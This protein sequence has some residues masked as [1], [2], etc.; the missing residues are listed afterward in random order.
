MPKLK[1]PAPSL[2]IYL[3]GGVGVHAYYIL[4]KYYKL[5]TSEHS[6]K[7]DTIDNATNV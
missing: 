5:H 6:S 7:S 2:Y 3:S 4:R 1:H